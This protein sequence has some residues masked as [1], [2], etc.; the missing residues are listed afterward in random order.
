MHVPGG[1]HPEVGRGAAEAVG[2]LE[3][4][5]Q[6]GVA[7][8]GDPGAGAPGF[9]VGDHRHVAEAVVQG[10][11]RVADHDDE[12]AS[13]HGGAIHVARLEPEGFAQGGG[14]VLPGGEDAVDVPDLETRVADRVGDR[15]QVQRELARVR[16]GPDL[17]A[18]VHAHDAR[19]VAQLPLPL[20]YGRHGAHR[21]G[22]KSGKVTS[23]LT[24]VKTTSTG[25]SH[26]MAL[27]EGSTLIRFD[28]M[29][30]PSSSCTIAS[31]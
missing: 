13:P 29:R 4:P 7:G 27:G 5:A 22:W 2:E 20:V 19:H 23:S 28:I 11:H 21:R 24:L 6:R 25:M 31:T 12:G 1:D 16:E 10:G 14:R 17:V 26:R 15:L 30:G 3:L 9:A 18:L 8:A